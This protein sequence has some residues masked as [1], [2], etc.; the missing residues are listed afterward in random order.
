MIGSIGMVLRSIAMAAALGI[1]IGAIFAARGDAFV[2]SAVIATMYGSSIGVL[3]SLTMPR[4][5]RLLGE[6]RELSQW[7]VYAAAM[8]VIIAVGSAITGVAMIALGYATPSQ[9]WNNYQ[10]GAVI[11]LS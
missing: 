4:L 11:S 2:P 5:R 1:A 7:F 9:F 6:M 3:A 10:F 8:L